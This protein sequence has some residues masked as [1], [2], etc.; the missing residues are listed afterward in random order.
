MKY[1]IQDRLGNYAEAEDP[2][3]AARA[4][5]SFLED[6][7]ERGNLVVISLKASEGDFLDAIKDI[8][9]EIN[10]TAGLIQD[11][12]EEG[13]NIDSAGDIEPRRD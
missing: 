6:N 10:K 3:G 12:R 1:I 2:G 7:D 13:G 5:Q 4:A 11:N 8:T 9:N